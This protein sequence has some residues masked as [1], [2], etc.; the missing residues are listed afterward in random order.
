[1]SK[2]VNYNHKSHFFQTKEDIKQGIAWIK[3]LRS[4]KF[5]QTTGTLQDRNGYCCLG[6]ACEVVIPK[7]KK[8]RAYYNSKHLAGGEPTKDDQPN[9]PLWLQNIN[10]HKLKK[11]SIK[12]YLSCFNDYHEYSF[13]E[14][15]DILELNFPQL[16]ENKHGRK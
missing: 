8:K 16:K 10:D 6:V 5:K 11:G 3:A 1:M 15:A 2:A 13:K 12:N 4:G 9:A 7:G 14:I